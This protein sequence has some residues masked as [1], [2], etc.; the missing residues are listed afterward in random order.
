VVELVAAR[1][2]LRLGLGRLHQNRIDLDGTE[3][4]VLPIARDHRGRDRRVELGAA[5]GHA[6]IKGGLLRGQFALGGTTA[7]HQCT[8]TKHQRTQE[9]GGIPHPVSPA[10]PADRQ[11]ASTG[12]L[13]GNRG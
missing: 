1:H 6:E 11:I 3:A 7:E 5:V 9:R 10:A 13:H 4:V 8:G 2:G 12:L